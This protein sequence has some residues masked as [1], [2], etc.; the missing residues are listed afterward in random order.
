MRRTKIDE[1]YIVGKIKTESELSFYQKGYRKHAFNELVSQ[2][3]GF[4]RD[5]PDTRHPR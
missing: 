5:I 2:R 4:L 3:I 1:Q